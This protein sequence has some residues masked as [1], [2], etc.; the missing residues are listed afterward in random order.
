MYPGG[1]VT[2]PHK[3]TKAVALF[4]AFVNEAREEQDRAN[5]A[6]EVNRQRS[7]AAFGKAGANRPRPKPVRPR[8]R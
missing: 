3:L 1:V 7:Q 2:Q 6:K 8:T 4:S 5:R